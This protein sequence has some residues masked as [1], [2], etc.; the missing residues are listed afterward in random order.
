LE[1]ET[2]YPFVCRLVGG[3]LG[4]DGS[5]LDR[6]LTGKTLG[7]QVWTGDLRFIAYITGNKEALNCA[8]RTS[9]GVYDC[10]LGGPGAYSVTAWLEADV[11]FHWPLSCCI[12]KPDYLF[13][14]GNSV[15]GTDRDEP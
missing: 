12:D 1:L 13:L 15:G 3:D 7:G 14:C 11:D 8:C 5:W 9:F 6:K 10:L 4:V 2:D